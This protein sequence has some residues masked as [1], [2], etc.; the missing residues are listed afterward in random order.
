MNMCIICNDFLFWKDVRK[1]L[2]MIDNITEN[3]PVNHGR[4][5]RVVLTGGPCGGKTSLQT[6]LSDM[7]ENMGWKVYRAAETATILLG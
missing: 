4:V 2:L 1:S 3:N 5:Y 6:T 7:F